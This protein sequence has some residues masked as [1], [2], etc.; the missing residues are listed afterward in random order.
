MRRAIIAMIMMLPL[1]A[2]ERTE[3]TSPVAGQTHEEAMVAQAGEPLT[4][5]QQAFADAN[6][7]MH[8]A[9][10]EIPSNADEAFMRGMLAHHRGAVE[11]AEIELEHGTDP[12]ARALAQTII[13][14]Q[15]AEIEQ[16]EAW[17]VREGVPATASAEERAHH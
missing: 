8:A 14:A 5:A 15:M 16:M 13:E 7:R 9:M 10:S 11:M 17:L 2:C 12:E 6:T 3:E 4:P 1:L